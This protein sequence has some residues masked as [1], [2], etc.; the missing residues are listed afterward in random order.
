L[1]AGAETIA[2]ALAVTHFHLQDNTDASVKLQAELREALPDLNAPLEF[3]VVEKLGYLVSR[4]NR[5]LRRRLTR[6]DYCSE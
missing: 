3:I 1:G 4:I 2:N 5:V 6:I